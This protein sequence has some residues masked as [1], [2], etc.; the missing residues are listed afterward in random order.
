MSLILISAVI[1][2]P[3]PTASIVRMSNVEVNRDRKGRDRASLEG[4]GK[5]A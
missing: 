3:G 1:Y 2:P 5:M 4:E